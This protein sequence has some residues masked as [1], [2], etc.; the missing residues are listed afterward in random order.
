MKVL[1]VA[2]GS[3]GD[4]EPAAALAPA[5]AAAGHRVA[6]AAN[7]EF[8]AV[9]SRG[10]ADFVALPG[11]ART[12]S[13]FAGGWRRS[14]RFLAAQAA[15]MTDYLLGAVDRVLEVA[16]AYDALLPNLT[17]RFVDDIAEGGGVPSLGLYTQPVHPTAEFP[18]V[19]LH[20]ATSLGHLGNRWAAR[21][22][23]AAATPFRAASRRARAGVG[24]PARRRRPRR[25]TVLHGFSP[26]VLARP[27]DW[28]PELEVVGYWRASTP[29][30]WAPPTELTDFL[31]AGPAP[32][33]IG[34][35]S[36]AADQ[37]GRL[38]E[39]VAH[40]LRGRR[41]IVQRGWAG[42]DVHDDDVLTI[43]DIPHDWL[44]PRVSAVVHHGGAGTAGAA[45]CAG[46]PSLAIPV[47]ADQPLWAERARRL[48]TGPAPLPFRRLT[49]PALAERLDA[50][51]D[52]RHRHAARAL[53]A[54]IAHDDGIGAVVD[55][56]ERAR[57]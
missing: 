26:H 19:L 33:L 45:F 44:L 34:F 47:Y 1:L 13:A 28:P 4:V 8:A 50:L 32:L 31:A 27:R 21:A 7:P 41:A 49:G 12:I 9:V 53:A 22:V 16:P 48:G 5:L 23:L 17:A 11:D 57:R 52:P 2:L 39:V 40:A 55:H 18:P 56:L 30:D 10:G 42:L 37:D 29:P 54:R 36:M 20:T 35:G 43:G 6:I 14:P 3:R 38:G 46:V 15:A 25:T 24:L 51:G